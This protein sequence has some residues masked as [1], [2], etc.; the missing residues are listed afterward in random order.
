MIIRNLC[1]KDYTK[2]PINKEKGINE[3]CVL[4]NVQMIL[5]SKSGIT[6]DQDTFYEK[7]IENMAIRADCY[8]NNYDRLVNIFMS[9]PQMPDVNWE[10]SHDLAD[11]K[12]QL[13]KNNPVVCYI[14]G[15]AVLAVDVIDDHNATPK[16]ITVIDPKYRDEKAVYGMDT[17]KI[18]RIGFYQ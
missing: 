13:A 6:I 4:T 17:A 7:A 5:E 2:A 16:H 14:G 11:L 1:Q 10:F 8:I 3:A 12:K 9:V 18:K 15:H